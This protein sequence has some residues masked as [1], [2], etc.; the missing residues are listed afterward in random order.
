MNIRKR[1]GEKTRPDTHC[2]ARD[3]LLALVARHLSPGWFRRLLFFFLLALRRGPRVNTA[4]GMD[5]LL[6]AQT[7]MM[8]VM[9]KKVAVGPFG[10]PEQRRQQHNRNQ[11]N[12]LST[13]LPA[14]QPPR[15][16]LADAPKLFP[17]PDGVRQERGGESRG[18]R[19]GGTTPR[20]SSQ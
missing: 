11:S 13:R 3:V 9:K 12:S 14:W 17:S 20:A 19:E 4:R 10:R 6:L 18:G 8:K 15:S 1:R 7:R 5:G 2:D 16:L